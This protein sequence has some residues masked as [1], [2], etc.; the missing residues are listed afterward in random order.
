M[1]RVV[2]RALSGPA[3]GIVRV[4]GRAGR[5]V[6]QTDADGTGI[7]LYPVDKRRKEFRIPIRRDSRMSCVRDTYVACWVLRLSKMTF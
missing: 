7:Q 4:P 6:A 1:R 2:C 5:D 3:S